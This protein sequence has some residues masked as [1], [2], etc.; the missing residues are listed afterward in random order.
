MIADGPCRLPNLVCSGPFAG[1]AL[2]AR[3]PLGPESSSGHSQC[4]AGANQAGAN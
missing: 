2:T 3:A 1:L 4:R